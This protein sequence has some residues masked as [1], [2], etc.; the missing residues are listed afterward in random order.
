MRLYQADDPRGKRSRAG[1][2]YY[3]EFDT[4]FWKLPGK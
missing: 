4:Q 3:D 2:K 1:R